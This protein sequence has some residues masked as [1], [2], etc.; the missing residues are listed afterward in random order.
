MLLAVIVTKDIRR[1]CA[2]KYFLQ[3]SIKIVFTGT[4]S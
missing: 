2:D 3:L 1:D 4:I